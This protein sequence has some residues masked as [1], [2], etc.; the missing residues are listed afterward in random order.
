[1][2]NEGRQHPA[3]RRHIQA[4]H[5][6][7]FGAATKGK[8]GEKTHVQQ[9]QSVK[10]RAGLKEKGVHNKEKKSRPLSS[11]HHRKDVFPFLH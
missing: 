11:S 8:R 2:T 9:L 6:V 1:M 4:A 7:P 3:G 10:Q 5:N